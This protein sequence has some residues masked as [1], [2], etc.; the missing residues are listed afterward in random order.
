MRKAPWR[1]TLFE[2]MILSEDDAEEQRIQAIR[3]GMLTRYKNGKRKLSFAWAQ[4]V[5]RSYQET[6]GMHPAIRRALSIKRGLGEIPLG[7]TSGQLLMG[8]ASSGPHHVDFNPHFPAVDIP[9]S[10]SNADLDRIYVI[11][12]G[13]LKQF[14]DEVMPYWAKKGRYDYFSQEMALN[15]PEVWRAVLL[16]QIFMPT[17]GGPLAHTIQDYNTFLSKGLLKIR[18]E[19]RTHIAALDTSDP[20]SLQTLER[21]EFLPI[22]DHRG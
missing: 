16:G 4:S 10:G 15:Y 5:T 13:E 3:E 7:L 18:E 6:E 1:G 14:Q 2:R 9:V 8:G 17:F 11:D 20:H 21:R 12:P 22:D 19:L